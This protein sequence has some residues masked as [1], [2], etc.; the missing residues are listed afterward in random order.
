MQH[1]REVDGDTQEST[2]ENSQVRLDEKTVDRSEIDKR[3]ED[4]SVRIVEK[5]PGEFRTL[6]KLNG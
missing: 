3:R 4:Q 2:N 5:S 6:T 1:L